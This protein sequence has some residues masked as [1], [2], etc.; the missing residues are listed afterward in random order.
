MDQEKY[1]ALLHKQQQG[2]IDAMEQTLLDNWLRQAEINR[3]LAKKVKEEWALTAGYEPPIAFD[4]EEEFTALQQRIQADEG[5]TS[6]QAIAKVVPM[7]PSRNW[8]SWAVAIALVVGIGT[9]FLNNQ[10]SYTPELIAN[11]DTSE[12]KEVLLGDGTTVWLNENS[13]LSYPKTFDRDQ[14]IVQLE[15]EA[16]FDVQKHPDQPFVIETKASMITVLGTSFN[17]RALSNSQATE[18]VVKTG[19]VRLASQKE[20][21]SVVLLPNEKGVHQ[22]TNNIVK[23]TK[24]ADLNELAWH[25]KVLLFKGTPI[26]EVIHH[27]ERTFNID[28]QANT[29]ALSQCTFSGRFPEPNPDQLLKAICNAFDIDLKKIN[30]TV[31]K[32]SGGTCQ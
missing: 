31:Y 22:H 16:F 21:Q 25:Q 11:T 1:I 15:G 24:T 10:S 32:L 14:R 4:I 9:W 3:V 5:I 29:S 8:L 28:I 23:K 20:N 18:V 17:V 7:K 13:K 2:T 19:K 30:D 12:K 27:L 6:K 26:P